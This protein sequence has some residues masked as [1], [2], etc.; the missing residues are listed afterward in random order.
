[1]A[2]QPDD[3]KPR[4]N[5]QADSE[6]ES[7]QREPESHNGQQGYG[8]APQEVREKRLPEQKWGPKR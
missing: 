5:R 7:T 2:N 3:Q 4:E 1:M 6:R 8:Q